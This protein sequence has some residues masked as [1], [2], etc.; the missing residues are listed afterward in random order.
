MSQAARGGAPLSNEKKLLNIQD[1]MGNESFEEDV[2]DD[3]DD[4]KSENGVDMDVLQSK[5]SVNQPSRIEIDPST[6]QEW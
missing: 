2:E 1:N 6:Y 3:E 4:A 5:M